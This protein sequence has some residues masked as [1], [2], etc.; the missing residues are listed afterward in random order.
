MISSAPSVAPTAAGTAEAVNM[1]ARDCTRRKSITSAGPAM[2]PPQE[3]S[4]LENVPMRRSTCLR[5]AV[6]LAR[7]RAGGPQHADAVGLVD[8]QPGAVFAAELD[9]VGE[10]GKVALHREHPVHHHQHPASVARRALEHRGEL[11]QPVV[12]KRSDPGAGHHHRVED[13]G[14]IA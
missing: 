13:R 14:V 11:G 7:A 5:H 9:H 6:G 3:A 1:N 2:K 8:H 12:A 10:R 4:D